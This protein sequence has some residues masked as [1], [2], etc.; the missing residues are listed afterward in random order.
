MVQK[1]EHTIVGHGQNGDLGD[2]SV[3]AS[4]TTS[5]LVDGG[6]VSVHVTGVTTTTGN[7][8]SGCRN[9]TKGVTVRRKVSKND[10]DVLLE[11]VG[12]VFGGG[13]SKTRSDDTLDTGAMS[14]SWA[15]EAALQHGRT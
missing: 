10:Q 2:G 12:V 5:A 11:L 1:V 3:S 8:F 13:Q 14:A 15:R 4:N 9:L 7:F 6:Q